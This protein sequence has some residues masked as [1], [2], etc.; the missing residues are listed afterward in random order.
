MERCLVSLAYVKGVY[1]GRGGYRGRELQCQKQADARLQRVLDVMLRR[2]DI[3]QETMG[4]HC[5]FS[6]GVKKS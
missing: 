3:I 4:S 2:L 1:V 5:F 6:Q